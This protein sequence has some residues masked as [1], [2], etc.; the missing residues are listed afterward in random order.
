MPA[1]HCMLDLETWGRKP[2]SAIRSIGAVMFDP[3]TDEIGEKY[4]ANIDRTSC[5]R[6]GLK[7]EAG[8]EEFWRLQAISN[9][10]AVNALHDKK[11]GLS[12][13]ACEFGIWW[14]A[15]GANHVWSHGINFDEP[16]W[17]TAV[18]AAGVDVPWH[19]RATRDTRTLFWLAEF[20]EKSIPREGPDHHALF[21]A[22]AQA[23][24]I[25]A[26]IRDLQRKMAHAAA[27]LFMSEITPARADFEQV[28]A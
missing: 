16:I 4:Y 18:E 9:P 5:E 25:Q 3:F 11:F 24:C 26:A 7:V 27:M 23:K 19:Y 6:F 10:A 21:D 17:R 13:V 15:V 22:I 14:H 28:L 20:D 1:T 2:G 12:K 8:T